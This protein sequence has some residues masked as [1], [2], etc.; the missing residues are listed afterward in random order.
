MDHMEKIE[1][2]ARLKAKIEAYEN[3]NRDK[4]EGVVLGLFYALNLIEHGPEYAEEK[5]DMPKV[6]HYDEGRDCGC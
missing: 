1:I 2:V 6:C 5:I 4:E 3:V